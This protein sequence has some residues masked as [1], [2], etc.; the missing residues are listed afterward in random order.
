MST[1]LAR[2]LGLS[3]CAEGV[4]TRPA[5][6]LLREIGCDKAQ[7]FLF[8]PPVEAPRIPGMVRNAA[9]SV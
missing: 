4:E 1:D 7:G 2:S 6:T 8:S 3:I 5:L 9:W